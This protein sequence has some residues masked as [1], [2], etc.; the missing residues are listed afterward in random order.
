V[1]VAASQPPAAGQGSTGPFAR[2]DAA[3][4]ALEACLDARHG[5]AR[6]ASESILADVMAWIKSP[7]QGVTLPFASAALSPLDALSGLALHARPHLA[8]LQAILEAYPANPR[9]PDAALV[10]RTLLRLG[11]SDPAQPDAASLAEAGLAGMFAA[12]F[13]PVAAAM[14]DEEFKPLLEPSAAVLAARVPWTAGLEARFADVARQVANACTRVHDAGV[15][16]LGPHAVRAILMVTEVR[17]ACSDPDALAVLLGRMVMRYPETAAPAPQLARF[18]ESREVAIAGLLR[19]SGGQAG[20]HTVPVRKALDARGYVPVKVGKDGPVFPGKQVRWP[21]TRVLEAQGFDAGRLG[22]LAPE[23][24]AALLRA[25]AGEGDCPGTPTLDTAD[26]V[27]WSHPAV[28]VRLARMRC[29]A[30]SYFMLASIAPDGSAVPLG[31]PGRLQGMY[32]TPLESLQAV[33]DVDGDGRL[34]ILTR[35][36]IFECDGEEKCEDA[37]VYAYDFS[38]LEGDRFTWFRNR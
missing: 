19:V 23:L 2:R 18:A 38:E 33:T 6:A 28:P 30:G 21:G 34:E 22:M 35:R 26:L 17:T 29:E 36:T 7:E 1:E 15:R 11:L 14:S 32:E 13:R 8:E 20:A 9:Q 31:L 24:R 37:V 3:L 25:L 10:G 12:A 5:S 4:A 27:I 16:G